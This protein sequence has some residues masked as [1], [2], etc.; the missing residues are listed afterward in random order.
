V[1][2]GMSKLKK[3]ILELLHK[4]PDLTAKEIAERLN[5]NHDSVKRMVAHYHRAGLL[6]RDGE[7]VKGSAYTYRL[8]KS[9]EARLKF[10]KS[11]VK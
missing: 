11:L 2:Q 5:H 3:E 7:G 1:V 9:G 6:S 10:F 4:N 8:T